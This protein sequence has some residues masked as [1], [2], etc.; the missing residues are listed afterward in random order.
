[1]DYLRGKIFK[2]MYLL[3]NMLQMYLLVDIHF[4]VK[5]QT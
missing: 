4:Y 3:D 2:K 5:D 1:M